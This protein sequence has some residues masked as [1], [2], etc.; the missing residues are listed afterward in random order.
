MN[1]LLTN[2]QDPQSVAGG[3]GAD[4]GVPPGYMGQRSLT[5]IVHVAMGSHSPLKMSPPTTLM[6]PVPPNGEHLTAK[7]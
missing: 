5:T 2:P 3:V 7:P 4:T 1:D 6:K